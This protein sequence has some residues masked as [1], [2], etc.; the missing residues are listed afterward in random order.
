VDDL[1]FRGALVWP[2][3]VLGFREKRGK[4]KAE[5]LGQITEEFVNYD[6]LPGRTR[7]YYDDIGLTWF[8]AFKLRS[9][10]VAI[11]LMRNNPVQAL[12]ANFV[13]GLDLISTS[14]GTALD[15]NIFVKAWEGMLP[16]SVG[17]G[18]ALRAPM[19]NPIVNIAF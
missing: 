15:D 5:A 14:A 10:K 7:S 19:M 13:P 9:A 6:R 12:L 16:N 17:P 3:P 2:E 18:M 4:T 8:Y 1:L 11:S